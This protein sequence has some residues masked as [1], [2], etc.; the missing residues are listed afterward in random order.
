MF[1]VFLPLI[2]KLCS[3]W[4]TFLKL[5]LTR[6]GFAIDFAESLKENSF[7]LTLIVFALAA[8]GWLVPAPGSE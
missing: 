8:V 2:L 6:L 1:A 5:N 4:P 3:T 7:P